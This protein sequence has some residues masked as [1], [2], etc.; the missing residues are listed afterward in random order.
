MPQDWVPKSFAPEFKPRSFT[1]EVPPSQ[2]IPKPSL[3]ERAT[4][5]G[6][7]DPNISLGDKA[8]NLLFGSK[9]DTG[10]TPI[11][12]D[13]PNVFKRGTDWLS[14]KIDPSNTPVTNRG[15]IRP[16]IAGSVKGVGD[17]LDDALGNPMPKPIPR[18]DPAKVEAGINAGRAAY[19]PKL[20]RL[21]LPPKSPE[22]R[23]I[24]GPA[25]IAEQGKTYPLD[26]NQHP[27]IFSGTVIPQE[28]AGGSVEIPADLAARRGTK[29]G[30]ASPFPQPDMIGQLKDFTNGKSIEIPNPT[31]Y[32]IGNVGPIEQPSAP[33][34]PRVKT[35]PITKPLAST[36][37]EPFVPKTFVP[38]TPSS[39]EVVKSSLYREIPK[40][41]SPKEAVS[42]WANGQEGARV[43]GRNLKSEFNDLASDKS[44]VD[45]YEAGDR[46]G[47]LADVQ[48]KLD[49]LHAE[50][51]KAG[52]F[53][54]EQKQPNYLRHEY[55][56]S[57]EEVGAAIKNYVSKNPSIAK[58]RRFPSYALAESEGLKRKYDNIPDMLEA[59]GTKIHR[60]IRN[61]EFYDYLG[62]TGQLKSG[63]LIEAPNSWTFQGSNKDELAKL[64]GNVMGKS[65]EG[66]HKVAGFTSWTKNLA[67]GSGV[68]KTPLNMHM[69]NISRSDIMARGVKQGIGD[70]FSGVFK[71]ARDRATLENGKN[72][73][74]DLVDHGYGHNIEDHSV[75]DTA[76]QG[77]GY[78]KKGI[79]K[80]VNMQTKLFEDP[81]FKTHLPAVKLRFANERVSELMKKGLSKDTALTQAATEAND[82]YGGINKILRNKTYNDLARIGLLA[83]DWLESRANLTGKG[84]AAL[85]GKSDPLYGKAF[86][87]SAGMRAVG[88]GITGGITGSFLN[89]S[90]RATNSADIPAGETSSGLNR[91]IPILG[92]SAEGI[93]IPEELASGRD[94]GNVV[95]SRAS[96]PLRSTYNI[97]NNEDAFH[98]PLRGEDKYGKP[99]SK[100]RGAMNTAKEAASTITPPWAIALEKLLSGEDPEATLATGFELP[101]K[102][103]HEPSDK[104]L[105]I[106]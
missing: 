53:K 24:G 21:E 55:E 66:L 42:Q 73:L 1:P 99:I 38:E 74:A 81:L 18:I 98:N 29:V 89:K 37:P 49:E 69:Y 97:L 48:K 7:L 59:Y 50:G 88:A 31:E 77:S 58:T 52:I 19:G 85:V 44:L 82:F 106:R 17:V 105:R 104:K 26:L 4:K 94:L 87:R 10:G 102:Y 40:G 80:V 15:T 54:A 3:W 103:N 34:T 71:P 28:F 92:S 86:A 6:L 5:G 2:V 95:M 76:K 62:K 93:R 100:V 33:K 22:S 45:K 101:L 65:P 36:T 96:Q 78:F 68:P 61:K 83:P 30:Q 90:K 46:S 11:A 9:L 84:V 70:F 56:Q 41:A 43:R 91:D 14:E 16:F 63:K 72:L 20:N 57:P 64:V 27:D 51:V 8:S 13:T 25:G 79:D 60:A 23:F 67:L 75:L 32:N 35:E 47:R 39:N 12:S